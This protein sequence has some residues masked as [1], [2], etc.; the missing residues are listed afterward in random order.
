L[1]LTAATQGRSKPPQIPDAGRLDPLFPF[2]LLLAI[3]PSATSSHSQG[4]NLMP[5]IVMYFPARVDVGGRN[6]LQSVF[7]QFYDY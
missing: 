2:T 1:S 5:L 7:A 3:S 4:R 6:S